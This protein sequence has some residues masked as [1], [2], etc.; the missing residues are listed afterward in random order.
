M[1]EQNFYLKLKFYILASFIKIKKSLEFI[2]FKRIDLEIKNRI[3]P[4]KKL[5]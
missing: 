5:L 1:F 4:G 2:S 3:V